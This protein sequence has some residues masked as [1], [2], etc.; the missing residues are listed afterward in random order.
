MR[1]VP[2]TMPP[3]ENEW[4]ECSRGL[5]FPDDIT[6]TA[7]GTNQTLLTVTNFMPQVAHINVD[8][9][10]GAVKSLVPDVT[11]DHASRQHTITI[12]HEIFQK[13]VLLRLSLIHI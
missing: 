7:H 10:C 2:R 3:V 12:G 9:V 5:F 6:N 13:G 4:I 1:G 11:E 8:D